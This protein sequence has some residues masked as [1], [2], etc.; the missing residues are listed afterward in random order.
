MDLAAA[1]GDREWLG[2]RLRWVER[3]GPQTAPLGVGTLLGGAIVASQHGLNPPLVSLVVGAGIILSFVTL[4]LWY[5]VL[6]F[7]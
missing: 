6:Q 4:P 7:L 5:M 3:G 1:A 2:T